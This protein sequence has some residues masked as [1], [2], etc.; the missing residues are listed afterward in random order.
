MDTRDFNKLG[1]GTDD[2]IDAFIQTV[3]AT[4]AIDKLAQQLMKDPSTFNR[5][6]FR[7]LNKDEALM[8]ELFTPPWEEQ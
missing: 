6:L 2:L 4:I 8:K 3:M 5:E 7:S 1:L